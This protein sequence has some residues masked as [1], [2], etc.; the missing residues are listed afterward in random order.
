MAIK[1]KFRPSLAQTRRDNQAALDYYR[2]LSPNADAP[3]VDVGAKEKRAAPKPS[4]IP[5]ESQEQ[6]AL[7]Q[8]WGPWARLKGIDHRLLF[9]IPNGAFFGHDAL[10][11]SIQMAKLKREGLRD[12]VC[13]LFLALPVNGAHGMFLE[14]KRREKATVSDDQK[15]MIGLFQ[16]QGYRALVCRGWDDGRIAIETYLRE[17]A[18]R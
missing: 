4:A 13:D 3:R 1:P 14:M 15:T 5:T 12:G 9:S 17:W 2:A 7:I 18:K 6:A 8:W 11:A 10:G 16:D